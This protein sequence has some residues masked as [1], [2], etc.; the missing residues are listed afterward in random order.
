[1][2]ATERNFDLEAARR[3]HDLT[4]HSYTS[5]RA[6]DHNLDWDNE[7]FKFKLYPQASA[8]ALPRELGLSQMRTLAAL[9]R[10]DAPGVPPAT[11]D[12]GRLARILFCAA[13]LT[14]TKRAGGRDYHFRAAPSAGAL[15]PIEVY[16]CAAAVD[17]LAQG[18]YHFCP[19]D[20]KLRTLREG[21]W[22]AVVS[23][24]CAGTVSITRAGAVLLLS[25][26]FWRSA[27]KYR[28]RAYR[29][30]FWDAGTMLANL[31]AAAA[32]EGIEARVVTAFVDREIEHLL[33]IDGEREG[34]VCL[35]LLNSSIDTQLP[36][37]IPAERA[38][39]TLA[40]LSLESLPLSAQERTY[41]ELIRLHRASKLASAAEVEQLCSA[42][43]EASSERYA[44]SVEPAPSASSAPGDLSDAESETNAPA[45]PAGA[46]A[47][48]R[49]EPGDV[50]E[51]LGLGETILRR[52]STRLF[53]RKPI[54]ASAL[55]HV[56]CAAS[57]RPRIDF[58]ALSDTYL[59]VNAVEGVEPGAYFYR[60]EPASLE[61]L[62]AGE[63]RAQAGYLCLEQPLGA[64]CSVLLCFMTDLERVLRTLGNRGYRGAHL[65]AGIRGGNAYLAAYALNLG[66]TGLTFYD[67]DTTEFFAPHGREKRPL[68][69]AAVGV[70]ARAAPG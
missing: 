26:I 67:D 54:S 14:R 66:A 50:S 40:A 24:L 16:L 34:V 61:L 8:L 68:L 45:T 49:L 65:E 32:A 70:P 2:E 37:R 52:G 62:K 48:L 64:D 18:L 35:V 22:R 5:V 58:P 31:A 39:Q 57:R 55:A 17:S 56:L 42:R 33:G 25:A 9:A 47:T 3:F 12:L 41:D 53:A 19:A 28:A 29:Y 44:D 27:W 15:Y 7:P 20:L 36:A 51:A 11:L 23:R 30:C 38:P 59:I 10:A 46:P 43:L 13:G 4:K 6:G 69:M 60:R 63:L 1:M 21:D